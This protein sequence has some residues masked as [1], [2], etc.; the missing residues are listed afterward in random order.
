MALDLTPPLVTADEGDAQELGRFLAAKRARLS[1]QD[2]GI[3]GGGRRR[4]PGLRREVVA[5]LAGVSPAY[6][7]RLEQGDVGRVSDA[8]VGAL[9]EALH[10]TPVE[11]DHF[12]RL[13]NP[14]GEA[15]RDSCS[16]APIRSALQG[17]LDAFVDMPAL[18][19]GRRSDLLAWN[20]LGS[21]VFGGLQELPRA[22]R[23]LARLVFLAP[24]FQDV[25]A[26]WDRKAADV[27]GQ[28]RM[29]AGFHPSDPHLSALV[30]ELAVRSET[31]ARL[32]ARHEVQERC[33]GVQVLRHPEAGLLELQVETFRV[34]G[35][36]DKSLVTYR[37]VTGSTTQESLRSLQTRDR[38]R[39]H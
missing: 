16:R 23:N 36:E 29:E 2:V 6:Y 15:R 4:V 10:L 19:I 3:P 39:Q 12:F 1:P 26:D 38:L 35:E 5:M 34:A 18:I 14:R 37:A 8:V 33:N 22:E 27:V 25:F 7:T 21:V 32:W 17:L 30:G 28:L 11:V 20:E 13:A 24:A 31:F 9:A